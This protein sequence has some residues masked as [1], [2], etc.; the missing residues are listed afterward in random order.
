MI[1]TLKTTMALLATAN[2][3]TFAFKI[4]VKTEHTGSIS[5]I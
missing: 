3:T 4:R 5:L 2:G 1:Y